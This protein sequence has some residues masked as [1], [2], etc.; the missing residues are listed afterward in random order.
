MC[1]LAGHGP[2]V[3]LGRS[4]QQIERNFSGKVILPVL[5]KY[6]AMA[7]CPGKFMHVA[8]CTA[9]LSEQILCPDH[10]I[11]IAMSHTKPNT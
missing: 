9:L 6:F 10:F 5:G 2:H 7:I 8:L 11:N 4:W 1:D 3:F